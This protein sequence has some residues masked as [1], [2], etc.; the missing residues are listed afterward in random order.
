MAKRFF[1]CMRSNIIDFVQLRSSFEL[2][3]LVNYLLVRAIIYRPFFDA[4]SKT[5][6]SNLADWRFTRYGKRLR[7]FTVSKNDHIIS[8]L[9]S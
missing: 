1:D 9:S 6:L 2:N 3:D 5:V 4:F 8:K 7:A